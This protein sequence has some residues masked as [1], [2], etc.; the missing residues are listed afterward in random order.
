MFALGKVRHHAAER[1]VDLYLRCDQV[2]LYYKTRH[3][4]AEGVQ[5]ALRAEERHARLIA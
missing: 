5:T 1:P 3:G 2:L 4:T